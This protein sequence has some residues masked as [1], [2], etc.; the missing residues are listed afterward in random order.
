MLKLLLFLANPAQL[1]A[2]AIKS[3]T[4]LTLRRRLSATPSLL[5][6]ERRRQQLDP[7]EAHHAD[8]DVQAPRLAW[9]A[10]AHA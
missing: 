6:G 2:G 10:P 4:Y 9:P 3:L 7:A 8:A 1:C 5:I